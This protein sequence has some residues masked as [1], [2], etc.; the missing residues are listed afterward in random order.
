VQGWGLR[1]RWDLLQI[2]NYERAFEI[3]IDSKLSVDILPLWSRFWE[4]WVN[5]L[6][7]RH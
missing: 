3:M 4:F 6:K 5:H 2:G 7:S 1:G